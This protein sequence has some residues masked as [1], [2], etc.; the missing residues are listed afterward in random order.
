[1]WQI[2]HAN[3]MLK[4][5]VGSVFQISLLLFSLFSL[6]SPTEFPG[7][8]KIKL[9][10]K[11]WLANHG[12]SCLG[13]RFLIFLCHWRYLGTDGC[14]LVVIAIREI[15]NVLIKFRYQV[16]S[17]LRYQILSYLIVLWFFKFPEV[18]LSIKCI[19]TSHR[20]MFY[21]DK[22]RYMGTYIWH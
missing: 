10:S 14:L 7:L 8:L 16:L 11:L 2:G 21:I 12:L 5:I 18:F 9:Q 20:I 3:Y 6:S 4:V 17:Y 1:M 22:L 15:R 13:R 19:N